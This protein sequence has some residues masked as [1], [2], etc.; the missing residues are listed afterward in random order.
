MKSRNGTIIGI[1][2]ALLVVG[3]GFFSMSIGYKNDEVKLRNLITSKQ[4]MNVV[5]HDNTFK[6]IS[7][8]AQV[9]KKFAEDFDKVYS[10]IMDKRYKGNVENAF[11]NVVKE[12]NPEFSN[13]LYKELVKTIN[14]SRDD[15]TERQRELTAM[16]KQHNDLL[17]VFPGS[18]FL[19]DIEPI[20]IQLVSSTHS[21]EVFKTGKDDDVELF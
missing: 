18:F 9:T 10:N 14:A 20:E 1:V 12:H 7:Q 13:D 8:G 19:S 15:F 16:G 17:T 3:I 21:Q 2:L 4:N 5:D 11:F 6:K